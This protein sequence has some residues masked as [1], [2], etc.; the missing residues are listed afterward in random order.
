[1]TVDLPIP[2]G[3]VV[4]GGPNVTKGYFKNKSKTNDDC[5]PIYGEHYDQY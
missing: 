1:L 3:E 4:I 5:E 2:Q